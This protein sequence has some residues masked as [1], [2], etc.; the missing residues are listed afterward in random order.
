[1]RSHRSG[2]GRTTSGFALLITVTLLA[3]LVLLLVS[4]AS[5]TRVE[6]QVASNSRQ[7][8]TARQNAL[9]GLKIALGQLQK[10]TGPD[11]RVTARA[12]LSAGAANPQWL[13]VWDS[14]SAG[15]SA[16]D[17]AVW[18]VSGN[19]TDPVAVKPSAEI[20]DPAAGNG[21]VWMINAAAPAAARVKVTKREVR[22]AGV[23]GFAAA[24][25]P[26]VGHYAYWVSDENQKANVSLTNPW[27]AAGGSATEKAY[28]FVLAQRNGIEGVSTAEA[29]ADRSSKLGSAGYPADDAGFEQALSRLVALRQLP[30][31][32]AA[33]QASLFLAVKNR[34]H[35]L[36]AYSRTLPADVA[37]GGLKKDLTAWLALP[38]SPVNA[39]RDSDYIGEASAYL[40]TWGLVRSYA[41]VVADGSAKQPVR[42]DTAP[43]AV[44]TQGIHPVITY[45]RMGF[46][47]SCAGPGKPVVFHLFPVVV[48]WNPSNVP[49]AAHDYE[50]RFD[51][52]DYFFSII[53][54]KA[55]GNQ[56]QST[57]DKY[58]GPV[59]AAFATAYVGYGKVT[60]AGESTSSL[61]KTP[62]RFRLKSRRI[63]PGQ[64]LVFTL[65]TTG[66]YAAGVSQMQAH[67]PVQADNSAL[68]YGPTMT[69]ADLFEPDGTTPI[70]YFLGNS[71]GQYDVSLRDF[72]D[73]ALIY[74]HIQ[75]SSSTAFYA[76]SPVNSSFAIQDPDAIVA[77][78]IYARTELYLSQGQHGQTAPSSWF[79]RNPRWLALFNPRAPD[80]L[81]MTGASHSYYM[82]MQGITNAGPSFGAGDEAAIGPGQDVSA[83]ANRLVLQ[84]FPPAGVPLMSLA[85]LQHANLSL[86]N[87]NPAYAVGNSLPNVYVARDQ[88]KFVATTRPQRFPF[89]N[90]TEVHDLSFELNRALWDGYFFSTV[91]ASL[92]SPS[93]LVPG[94]RL[95]NAR[96]ALFWRGDPAANSNAEFNE[97][98]NPAKA[99]A[100]LFVDGGFNV[101]STSV[102]AWRA[103]L[104]AHNRA[105]SDPAAPADYKH[106][107]SRYA[108]SGAGV[109]NAAPWA[110]Y[111]VL[112]DAQIDNLAEKI[113]AEV[114]TRGPFVSVADFVNRRL[115]ND[116][117]GLK[118]A[119][120]AAIDA[121][122]ADTSIASADR[123][124]ARPPFN[125][126]ASAISTLA[127]ATN[128]IPPAS[129]GVIRAHWIGSDNDADA[130]KPLASRAACAPGYLSQA[131]M[132]TA[133]GP[134]L[135]ARGDTFVVRAYGDVNNPAGDVVEGRAWCEAVVQRLHEWSDPSLDPWDPPAPGSTNDRFGRRYRVI[136]FRW[137]NESD[138]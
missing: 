52:L 11:R 26:V 62:Y 122:D 65:D 92:A 82:D 72:A 109:S 89:R 73:G 6:T 9:M 56:R 37:K 33:A 53:L 45:A 2:S 101:N 113:A 20:P 91:P 64:S 17:P 29:P 7:S 8:D 103:L 97:L 129:E 27:D 35:D 61:A 24:D 125:D 80:S 81:R 104:Y 106:P 99:A 38:D 58:A 21:S 23:P 119:L 40:P 76:S 88:T 138:I 93:S 74:H 75:S 116:A 133:I 3:F 90:L 111:R 123:I 135:T 57:L 118:G 121:V 49:L 98:K 14:S 66:D 107:F 114:R 55:A 102:Q 48:L 134:S 110:G 19:E 22:S 10:Y 41:G 39:P 1:M 83:P 32:N 84:E 68:I 36:T 105:A 18:L 115:R 67:S 12:D 5:L 71:S 50:M 69:A 130:D 120:Q 128:A 44:Q 13:G 63:E 59:S 100:H 117:T 77:P 46:N 60:A 137:L 87:L 78:M 30:M 94:Y 131:D 31:A 4:L 108:D 86:M 126:P 124:N 96:H 70:R 132:L 28:S 54:G 43:G 15:P 16:T 34:P 127:A 85:Q 47:V 42:E 136:A 25:T 95:P 112:S 79:G 51:Y